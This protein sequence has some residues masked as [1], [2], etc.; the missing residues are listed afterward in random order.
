MP[1]F[2]EFSSNGQCGA[3]S[4]GEKRDSTLCVPSKLLLMRATTTSE[5]I[6]SY[7]LAS[8]QKTLRSII[9]SM[10]LAAALAMRG[11]ATTTAKHCAREIATWRQPAIAFAGAHRPAGASAAAPDARK[12]H[13]TF[14]RRNAGRCGFLFSRYVVLG[15][16]PLLQRRRQTPS[17]RIVRRRHARLDRRVLVRDSRAREGRQIMSAK[18]IVT[19]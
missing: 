15:H 11:S 7:E 4:L 17:R 19:S 8:L 18:T 2:S 9:S 10:E 12:W 16:K 1:F 5:G 3:E 14:P 6:T 13:R